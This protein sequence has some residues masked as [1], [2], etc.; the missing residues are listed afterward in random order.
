MSIIPQVAWLEET[1]PALAV[2]G[3]V[4]D[5]FHTAMF[6]KES[7]GAHFSQRNVSLTLSSLPPVVSLLLS[8]RLLSLATHRLFVIVVVASS[9]PLPAP[10]Y[11]DQHEADRSTRGG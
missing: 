2:V 3:Y 11:S 4:M 1:Y 6:S 5:P 10:W 8:A 7:V 9:P